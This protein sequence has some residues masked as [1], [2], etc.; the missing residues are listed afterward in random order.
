MEYVTELPQSNKGKY[1]RKGAKQHLKI[2]EAVQARP[3]EWMLVRQ[4]NSNM[5]ANSWAYRARSPYFVAFRDKPIEVTVRGD[6]VFMRWV[7]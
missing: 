3:G 2:L 4:C 7:K 5:S 6:Q 1:P